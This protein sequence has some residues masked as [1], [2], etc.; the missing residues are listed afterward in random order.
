MEVKEGER[1]KR[2]IQFIKRKL[3][4]EIVLG[5]DINKYFLQLGRL[6]LGLVDGNYSDRFQVN[7]EIQLRIDVV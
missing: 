3:R 5:F 2:N 1:L 4:D 6:K 7:M